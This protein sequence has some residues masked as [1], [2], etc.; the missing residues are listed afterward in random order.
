M[1]GPKISVIVP[2]YNEEESIKKC[3][4]SLF[5]Q[6]YPQNQ[7][8]ILLVDTSTDK[9]KKIVKKNFPLVRIFSEE[10]R[11]IVF[12]RIK[13]AKEARGEIVVYLDA[14]TTAPV[15]WLSKI[16]NVY[17]NK[18]VVA[19]GG[20]LDFQPKTFFVKIIQLYGDFYNIVFKTMPGQNLSFRK[21]VYEKIGGFDP[22]INA[23]EDVYISSVLN[24]A[25]KVI[26]LKNNKVITSSR[27]L[28]E[29][30]VVYGLKFFINMFSVLFFHKPVVYHFEAVRKK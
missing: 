18:E 6:D 10:K 16:A 19:V 15:D 23:G 13:G 7:F 28:F 2:S 24:K 12:A 8:E 9:T 25:G 5:R 21:S 20:T 30:N 17:Q 27:R 14:D 11:G 26:I 29:G 3:I 4:D 22:K 1:N